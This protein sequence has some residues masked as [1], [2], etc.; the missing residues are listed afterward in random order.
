MQYLSCELFVEFRKKAQ[1]QDLKANY[2]EEIGKLLWREAEC[3]EKFSSVN[4]KD[5]GD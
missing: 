4:M 5:S 2:G 3:E 1:E